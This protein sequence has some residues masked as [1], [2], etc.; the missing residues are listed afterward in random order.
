MNRKHRTLEKRDSAGV[1]EGH[2]LPPALLGCV[3]LGKGGSRCPVTRPT[4]PG[5][6]GEA[7]GLSAVSLVQRI[8][9]SSRENHTAQPSLSTH[10]QALGAALVMF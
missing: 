2:D 10:P 5:V 8:S 6:A 9:S 7:G 4:A 3:L 1:E